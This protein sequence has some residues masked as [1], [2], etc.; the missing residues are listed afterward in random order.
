MKRYFKFDLEDHELLYTFCEITNNI[1]AAV[2]TISHYPCS[3]S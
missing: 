1:P 3:S 2:E